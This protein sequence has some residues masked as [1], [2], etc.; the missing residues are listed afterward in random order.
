MFYF[1]NKQ[2]FNV[3]YTIN[4]AIYTKK[5]P[6]CIVTLGNLGLYVDY[7]GDCLRTLINY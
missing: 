6:Y 1:F 3:K 7:Y 4:I 2:V 5:T